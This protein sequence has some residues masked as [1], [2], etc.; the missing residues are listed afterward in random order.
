MLAHVLADAVEDDDGVVGRVAGDRQDRGDDVEREVVAE[1]RQERE[2]DQQIVDGRHHRADGEAEL[3]AESDVEQDAD[4]RQHGRE[5]ALAR[6]SCPTAGPTISVPAGLKLP[7][8]AVFSASTTCSAFSRD[9]PRLFPDGRDAN[10]V[11]MRRFLA[12]SLDDG[13]LPFAGH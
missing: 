7:T 12:V 13:V 9:P 11:L 3:E 4:K 1:E 10:Q 8:L 2:R 5:N 6:R